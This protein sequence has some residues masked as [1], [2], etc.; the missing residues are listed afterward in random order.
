LALTD[1]G[2]SVRGQVEDLLLTNLPDSLIDGLDVIRDTRNALDR[3]VIGDE[4]ILHIIIPKPKLDQLLKEP[5]ADNLEFS[6]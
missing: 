2:S 4:H 1:V 6:R 5:R 3:P